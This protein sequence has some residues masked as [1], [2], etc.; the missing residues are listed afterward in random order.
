MESKAIEPVVMAIFQGTDERNWQKVE[1]SFATTV[2]LDYSSLSGVPASEMTRQA[3]VRA[4]SGFLPGFDSTKHNVT[5]LSVTEHAGSAKATCTGHVLHWMTING[6]TDTWI[7]DGD[8]EFHLITENGAW[9]VDAMKFLLA[10]TSGNNDLPKLAQQRVQDGVLV[11]PNQG[12]NKRHPNAQIVYDFYE[13]FGAP[14]VDRLRALVTENFT[15]H[16]PGTSP[17][18]G[19]WEGLDAVLN[20]VRGIGMK[21]GGGKNGFELKHVFANDD[22]AVAIHRDYYTGN[23]NHFDLLHMLYIRFENGRMAELWEVPFDQKEGDR[24]WNLQQE[25]ARKKSND[26]VAVGQE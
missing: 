14:N 6:K 16:Y 5:N 26:K 12:V 10:K 2:L 22:Y 13:A 4:W 15:W 9:K 7:A 17:L 18:A 11:T 20:G 8:Y 23:D 19:D 25:N 3:I 24:F 21:L 1:N